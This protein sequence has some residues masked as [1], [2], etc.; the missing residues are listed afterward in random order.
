MMKTKHI[1]IILT[2]FIMMAG[3]SVDK[4]KKETTFNFTLEQ[5]ADLRILRYQVPGF[6]ELSLDQKKLIYYLGQA[7]LCGRDIIWDQNGK[8]NL[9]IR[10]TLENIYK[11]YTGDKSAAF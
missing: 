6:D 4:R 11:T 7:A 8:Y 2:V 10:Q 1:V 5:F 9:A 3:C